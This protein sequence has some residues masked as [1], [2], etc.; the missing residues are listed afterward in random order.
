MDLGFEMK[1]REYLKACIMDSFFFD[2]FTLFLLFQ[3]CLG[4]E[5]WKPWLF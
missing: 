1:V 3:I 4:I 5:K 2:P